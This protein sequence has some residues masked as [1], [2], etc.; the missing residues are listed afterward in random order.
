M[1]ESKILDCLIDAGTAV[2]GFPLESAWQTAIRQH[3]AVSLDH[4]QAVGEFPLLDEAEPAPVFQ[5]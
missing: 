1:N 3:L 5:A 4:A 2:L